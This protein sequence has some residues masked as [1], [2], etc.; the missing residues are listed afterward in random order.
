[1]RPLAPR[2]TPAKL[3]RA[4]A[5]AAAALLASTFAATSARAAAEAPALPEQQWEFQGIFGT[6]ERD[7]QQRGLQVYRQVCASCHSLELIAFRNLRD[8]GLSE[9]QIT[10]I[11]GEYEVEDGPN[12]EGEMF[13]RP[14]EAADRFPAPFPNEQAAR[15]ANNG[16]YP[17]DLSLIT[18]A[19]L[20]SA[21]YIY[22]LLT[23]YRDE[24]P[25]GVELMPGMYYN[26]YFAGHQIA[27]A[28]PLV[29][30]IVE[31]EDGTEATVSQMAHDVTTFLA[32]AAEPE[33]EE[34]K[35]LGVKA[36]LFLTVFTGLLYAVK[37]KIWTDV[38]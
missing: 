30:G 4:S 11:A 20:G 25:E 17:P 3:W 24:P 29:E 18:K 2:R 28:P 5:M 38:H 10:A 15:Y 35:R 34:R 14:A 9:D 7:A 23:G 22:A 12:D 1:M 6:F 32:W 27:M 26:D 36:I 37:R 13:M 19:R 16:A 21:D 31:Y 8:L 33:L